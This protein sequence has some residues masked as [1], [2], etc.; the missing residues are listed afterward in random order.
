MCGIFGLMSFKETTDEKKFLKRFRDLSLLS[1]SRG[2]EASGICLINTSEMCV[3]KE[4][5]P[6][7]LLFKKN[8]YKKLLN[9]FLSR[10]KKT[11]ASFVIALG[12]SRMVTNGDE[13]DPGN[14]QPIVKDDFISLH[15]GIIVNDQEIWKKNPDLKKKHDV[16]SEVVNSLISKFVKKGFTIEG[17]IVKLYSDIKGSASIVIAKKNHPQIYF[18]TNTGSL[19]FA[20]N[21]A[22]DTFCFASE[23]AILRDF[24][25]KSS[26]HFEIIHLEAKKGAKIS[27]EEGKLNFFS[28]ED[29]PKKK[30]SNFERQPEIPVILTQN[31]EDLSLRELEARENIK[32]C[33]KCILPE[34]I[35]FLSFDK[36]GV[37]QKC[38]SYKKLEFYGKDKLNEILRKTKSS[39]EGYN[40]IV[41]LSG[42]RD[43]SFGLHYLAKRSWL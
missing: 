3:Y 20:Q 24:I 43:S 17:S 42:G 12:H 9:D 14:N 21:Q 4:P 41:G 13:T 16:D 36:N 32:R 10:T 26:D 11:K 38:R 5:I 30:E 19:Y 1:E 35:P 18:A 27:V 6:A 23:K 37:C 28:L 40:C 15:N 7:S 25:R 8:E 31:F 39:K 33:T 22:N 34:T 2:K 29:L